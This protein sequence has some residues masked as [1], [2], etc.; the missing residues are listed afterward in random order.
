MSEVKGRIL[1]P[2]AAAVPAVDYSRGTYSRHSRR[3]PD[4]IR[5]KCWVGQIAKGTGMPRVSVLMPAYNA[6]E[7]IQAAIA[8]VAF[9]RR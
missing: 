5:R 3:A 2:T 4:P 7:H 8:S 9:V 1:R 6:E